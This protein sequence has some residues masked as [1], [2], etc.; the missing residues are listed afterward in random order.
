MPKQA[1]FW[2]TTD[3]ARLALL[4]PNTPMHVMIEELGRPKTAIWRKARENGLK[5]SPEFLASEHSGR[6]HKDNTRGLAT[7][8]KTRTAHNADSFAEREAQ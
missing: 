2:K 1:R 7:R 4:Y 8:F 5:R 3:V 6:M